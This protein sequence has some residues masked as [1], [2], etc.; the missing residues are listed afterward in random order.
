M[1]VLAVPLPPTSFPP[2]IP[3]DVNSSRAVARVVPTKPAALPAVD[4]EEAVVWLGISEVDLLQQ[5]QGVNDKAIL[6]LQ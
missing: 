1:S 5:L 2:Q 4:G 6:Q 3:K